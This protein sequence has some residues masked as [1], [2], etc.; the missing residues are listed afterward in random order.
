MPKQESFKRI[1]T[2]STL[3]QPLISCRSGGESV[4][5]LS[6]KFLRGDNIS[7]DCPLFSP[8]V[9]ILFENLDTGS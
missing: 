7:F 4:A 5:L 2:R 6:K 9:I 3:L 8:S 1:R